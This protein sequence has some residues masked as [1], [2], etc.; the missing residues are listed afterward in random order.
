MLNGKE[1]NKFAVAVE[2]EDDV[3]IALIGLDMVGGVEVVVVT[4][5]IGIK[6][7]NVVD[8]TKG[9]SINLTFYFLQFAW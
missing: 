2:V 3:V 1:T 4:V 9:F 7:A 5:V 6:V 8:S